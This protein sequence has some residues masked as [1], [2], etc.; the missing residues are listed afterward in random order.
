[1]NFNVYSM[2]GYAKIESEFNG[3]SIEVELRSVNNRYLEIQVRSPRMLNAFE[4]SFKEKIKEK[5]S[6]GSVN[7]N[8]TIGSNDISTIPKGYNKE[9][10]AGFVESCQQIK[11]DFRPIIQGEINLSDVLKSVEALNFGESLEAD[12]NLQKHLLNQLDLALDRMLQMR[13]TEGERLK[14]DLIERINLIEL[15]LSKVAS[16]LPKRI[17]AVK[18]KIKEKVEALMGDK[19]LDELRLIQEVSILADKLD[20]SE[21]I[22]R[23]KSHNKLFNESICAPGPHGKKLNFILQEMGREANTLGTKSQFTEIT[24]IAVAIK[25]EVEAIREQTMNLE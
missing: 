12:D 4:S 9:I 17:E 6:R 5:L 7:C 3:T 22:I 25:E 24:H 23:F 2:T 14:N 16:L 20:V 10:V 18:N 13:G 15:N 8:I 19:E 11:A 1:M 21:E